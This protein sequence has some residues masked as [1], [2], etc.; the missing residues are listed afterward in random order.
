MSWFP[1]RK[2]VLLI[3][4]WTVVVAS[5]ERRPA[6]KRSAF[7]MARLAIRGT[8]LRANGLWRGSYLLRSTW[9]A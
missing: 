3:R 6:I 8:M 7:A 2:L 5:V 9:F 4:N 1:A